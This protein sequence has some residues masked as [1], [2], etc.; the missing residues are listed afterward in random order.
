MAWES[1]EYAQALLALAHSQ[2]SNSPTPISTPSISCSPNPSF[3]PPPHTYSGQHM[4]GDPAYGTMQHQPL[5]HSTTI[6]GTT[7]TSAW[8]RDDHNVGLDYYGSHTWNGG[9][10]IAPQPLPSPCPKPSTPTPTKV[11]K[12]YGSTTKAAQMN[13]KADENVPPLDINLKDDGDPADEV[14][15][16]TRW[17]ADKKTILFECILGPDS[18]DI[19]DLPKIAP[20]AAFKKASLIF[21]SVVNLKGKD[22][23]KSMKSQF[24]RS[25]AT[26]S[27]IVVFE[28]YTGNGG[29]DSDDPPNDNGNFFT[30]LGKKQPSKH[31][32]ID[33]N[34]LENQITNA[35]AAGH[36]VGG[37]SAKVI[38]DWYGKS[39][40]VDRAVSCHSAAPVSDGSGS[41][42]ESVG[43]LTPSQGKASHVVTEPKFKPAAKF[44]SQTVVSMA[45]MNEF[46]KQKGEL[47][48]QHFEA[49]Q[50]QFAWEEK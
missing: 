12:P 5:A 42:D 15:Q 46:L 18:N 44:K 32:T 43:Q 20:K 45:I 29:S 22:T 14:I 31:L 24:T 17:S 28:G 7:G 41:E 21:L 40:K 10:Q 4:W 25:M 16:T 36:N 23:W 27:L 39:P 26:Y 37:L 9:A 50:E 34:L 6:N 35:K 11:K 2:P 47:D 19:F 33:T 8:G 38:N 13:M 3:V 49:Q 1:D 48:Q 30:N